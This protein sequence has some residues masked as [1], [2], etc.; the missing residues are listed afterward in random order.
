MSGPPALPSSL[1]FAGSG[2]TFHLVVQRNVLLFGNIKD[3]RGCRTLEKLPL[4]GSVR[5]SGPPWELTFLGKAFFRANPEPSVTCTGNVHAGGR[6]G[7]VVPPPHWAG[8]TLA[9]PAKETKPMA[10][11]P[12][13]ALLPVMPKLPRVLLSSSLLVASLVLLKA[14][15][16]MEIQKERHCGGNRP[17]SQGKLRR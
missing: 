10:T 15:G 11:W 9:L 2:V 4:R 3:K 17:K 12:L 5:S 6:G 1:R 14:G 16:V 13:G 8:Q 7:Y